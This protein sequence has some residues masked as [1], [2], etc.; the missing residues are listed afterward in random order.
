VKFKGS[1]EGR[2]LHE[3]MDDDSGIPPLTDAQREELKKAGF[4]RAVLQEASAVKFDSDQQ[5]PE[6]AAGKFGIAGEAHGLVYGERAKTYGHPRF[7][8]TSIGTVWTG[9]LQD[10]LKEGAHIDAHRVAVLMTGL[11]LA[12]LV[13]SPGHHDSRVDTIGYMLTMERLDEPTE[14]ELARADAA[15]VADDDLDDEAW[16]KIAEAPV[17]TTRPA[18]MLR[19]VTFN[20]E[21]GELPKFKVPLD[22]NGRGTFTVPEG[23][24]KAR[25]DPCDPEEVDKRM[26]PTETINP[27]DDEVKIALDI[28]KRRQDFH[29]LEARKLL[30]RGDGINLGPQ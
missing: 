28:L 14:E 2:A 12:R 30:A 25:F 7:D 22:E 24:T 21:D 27:S 26:S 20:D 9:L 8:F 5:N 16:R 6:V 15:A 4:P 3:F 13:K 1:K 11:K 17:M 29:D 18:S 10:L 19:P 23:V